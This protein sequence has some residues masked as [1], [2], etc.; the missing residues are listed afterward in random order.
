MLL[1]T[2]LSIRVMD[3]LKFVNK[4]C[5]SRKTKGILYSF[6]SDT[7]KEL[8]NRQIVCTLGYDSFEC[9]KNCSGNFGT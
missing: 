7:Q 3:F 4:L 5:K 9:F 2:R 8:E 6:A 1:L